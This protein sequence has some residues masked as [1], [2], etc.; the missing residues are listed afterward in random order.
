MFEIHKTTLCLKKTVPFCFRHYFVKFP[1]IVINF[2]R[3]MAK[4]LKLYVIYTFTTKPDPFHYTTLLNMDVLNFY[5]IL[6]LLQSDC[7]D[8]VLKWRG[9]TVVATFLLRSHCQTLAGH[10]LINFVFQQDDAPVHWAR[11]IIAFTE[12]E[13]EMQ[14]THRHLSACV[15]VHAAHFEHE[16]WQFWA[17]LSLQLTTL[18]NKPYFGLLCA[19]SVILANNAFQREHPSFTR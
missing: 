14:E 1:W 19:D 13:R 2:D 12:R 17:D 4:W 11:D 8:L 16:R 6:D 3:C 10:L 9:H 15:R 18:R 7:W 5:L